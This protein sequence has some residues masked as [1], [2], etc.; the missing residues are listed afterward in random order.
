MKKFLSIKD[1]SKNI[2]PT[3]STCNGEIRVRLKKNV[4]R[5]T[6][7][8][9]IRILLT[10]FFY[11]FF[12]AAKSQVPYGDNPSAGHTII[13]N[14]VKH[15]YEAYGSGP[16]L[17]LIHGNTTGIPG[18]A[19]QISYFASKY[20]VYAID[21]RGRGKSELGKDTLS[22]I[23]IARDMA[24][25]IKE[26]KMD[27]V[28]VIGKSDGGIVSLLLGIYYPDHIKKI[29]AFGANL[30]PD[31]TALYAA[32]VKAIHDERVHADKML[33]AH[34]TTSNW[35]VVQQKNRMMEFQPHISAAELHT[36]QIPVLIMS[37][38]RD[39]IKEEHTLFIYKN[40]PFAN[41]C[42][43]PGEKHAIPRLNPELFN[44]TVDAYFS[45][46][47]RGDEMRFEK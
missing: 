1:I 37:C 14:G 3:F 17:L 20:T 27:S 29:A 10:V 46:P 5:N 12:I 34:D 40:I 6:R 33:A 2:Q 21:C 41:L 18:M 11:S 8:Y 36:I 39:L 42:I 16:P 32:T 25:F 43:F 24:A 15:Y 30:W 23:Q 31:T 35:L 28:C 47:Y 45:K 7:M 44:T 4:F 22:F 26:M 9:Y 13:L 38:D 19:A